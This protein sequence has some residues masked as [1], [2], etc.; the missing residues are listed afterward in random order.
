MVAGVLRKVVEA[1]VLPV[2]AS[3]LPVEASVLPVE[4]VEEVLVAAVAAS[5]Q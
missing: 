3:V 1:S 4:V 2:E 5:I